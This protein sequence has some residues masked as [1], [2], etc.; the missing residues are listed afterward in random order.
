MWLRP[1]LFHTNYASSSI[2]SDEKQRNEYFK[3]LFLQNQL[4]KVAQVQKL[5]E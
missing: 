1:L 3:K 4:L 5:Q 2:L